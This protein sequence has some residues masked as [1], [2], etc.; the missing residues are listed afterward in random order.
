MKTK[1]TNKK[2]TVVSQF[3]PPNFVGGGEISTYN[4]CK[5]LIKMD[6]K[7]TVITPN[8]SNGRYFKFIKTIHPHY[9]CDSFEENYF[10][11]IT[12]AQKLG[13]GIYWASD[14]YGA[15]FL[16]NLDVKKIVTVR[17]HWPICNKSLNIL[18]DYSSCDNCNLNNIVKCYGI[19]NI[20]FPRKIWRIFKYL[21]NRKFRKSILSKFNH[22]VFVSNYIA[23][24]I[25]SVISLKNYSVIYN[26][27]SPEFMKKEGL[28]NF[29]NKNIIFLG[30]VKEFKGIDIL[31]KAMQELIRYDKNHNLIIIGEGDLNKYKNMVSKLNLSRNV[32][33]LGKMKNEKSSVEYYDKSTFVILPSLC[34]ETFGRTIIEGMARKCITI[35]TNRGGPAEIIKK[36]ENGFLYDVDDYQQ[37]AKIIINLYQNPEMMGKIQEKGRKFAVE[38][39][40]PEK[41]AQK[42][43]KIF[44]SI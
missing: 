43:E 16:K 9:P 23:N 15:A 29:I 3:W 19:S 14:F 37:L 18:K 20:N 2:I 17:D 33:F 27:L 21:N 10:K 39:F 11:K 31:L 4:V 28:K 42:Y 8:P 38:N 26:P 13:G 12:T 24:K 25:T 22:V 30:Y 5:Q 34:F 32:K 7:I 41:I 40:S 44:K 6:Y 36:G 35:A 1:K